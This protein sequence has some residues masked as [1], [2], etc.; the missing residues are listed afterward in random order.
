MGERDF[1]LNQPQ[2]YHKFHDSDNVLKQNY[3]YLGREFG[4]EDVHN[5]RT[6]CKS[7]V[8]SI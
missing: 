8:Q 5:L 3:I 7:G 2:I 1:F 4:G 6:F